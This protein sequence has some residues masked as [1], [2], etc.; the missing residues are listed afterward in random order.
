MSRMSAQKRIELGTQ[1]VERWTAANEGQDRSVR[2]VK[3]M[4]VRLGR[5]RGLTKR[6]REW[7]DSAVLTNPPKPQNE[8]QVNQLRA[9]AQL[10]GMEK[11]SSVLNDFAW[12]LSRG[13]NLSEKQVAFMN[14]LTKQARDIRENGRWEP[15]PEERKAI[16]LGV[17]FGKRYSAY[18]L[19]GCPGISKALDECASW[20]R[21]DSSHVDK[22][23]ADK[24]AGLCKGD[25]KRMA[26]A[27]DRWP[28]GS[29]VTTRSGQMGLVLG[30]PSVTG[31]GKPCL[32][33][34]I[35][36]NPVEV[37]LSEIK[38]ERRKKAKVA[39]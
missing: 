3:D 1:M 35:D 28:E 17:A 12:K 2:F 32:V 15:S 7:Y 36:A 5:G 39:A 37:E 34:L 19:S 23:S 38:K 16:E 20:L 8:E 10:P 27:E 31:R 11:A 18:Y 33:L 6:Q 25:R 29:L 9:D 21:G 24:V 22:W 30:A 4:L 13:Y 26:D 14:K